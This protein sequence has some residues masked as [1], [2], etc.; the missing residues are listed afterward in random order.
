[1]Y[2]HGCKPSLLNIYCYSKQTL[3]YKMSPLLDLGPE[4]FSCHI[5]NRPT[6]AVDAGI[7]KTHTTAWAMFG[8]LLRALKS[9][10][11]ML[12]QAQMLQD[13]QYLKHFKI[14]A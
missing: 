2:V 8:Y 12:L 7:P 9:A 4:D 5:N 11:K 6:G 3:I 10:Y 13:N 14:N 1:M